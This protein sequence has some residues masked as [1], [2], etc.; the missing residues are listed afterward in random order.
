MEEWIRNNFQ[1][2]TPFSYGEP[3]EYIVT[4]K[5][6]LPLRLFLEIYGDISVPPTLE[7][8][9]SKDSNNIRGWN[10]YFRKWQERGIIE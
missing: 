8:L 4:G 9:T 2:E 10:G 1:I 5:V 6:M 3:E 7:A